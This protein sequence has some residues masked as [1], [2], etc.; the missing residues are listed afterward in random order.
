V[1]ISWI[2][3]FEGEE[4]RHHHLFDYNPKRTCTLHI[5][6]EVDNSRCEGIM[7][8]QNMSKRQEG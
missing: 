8:N 2:E 1:N 7:K 4:V 6:R 3:A 5:L